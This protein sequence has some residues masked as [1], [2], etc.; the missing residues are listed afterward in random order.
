M[1]KSTK[2]QTESPKHVPQRSC[3]ACRDKRDKRDLIR[4]VCNASGII[5]IDK[6]KKMT[7]RGAYLCPVY[8]CWE[9]AL[10]GNRLQYALKTSIGPETR[11]LLLEF[12]RTLSEEREN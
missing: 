7:G 4:L 12:A 5:E 6:D 9:A 8:N 3:I 2:K 11:Q 10:K 1:K